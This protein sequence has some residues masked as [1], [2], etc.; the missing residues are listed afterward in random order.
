[1]HRLGHVAHGGVVDGVVGVLVIHP[2]LVDLRVVHR[3]RVELVVE[4]EQLEGVPGTRTRTLMLIGHTGFLSRF[5]R[6][7]HR[8]PRCAEGSF[9]P[10]FA[11]AIR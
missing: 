7:R 1:M 10:S 6:G 3:Q 5:A 9:R 4:G 11:R 8:E 2:F